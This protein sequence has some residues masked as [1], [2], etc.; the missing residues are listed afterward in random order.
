MLPQI[1]K[2]ENNKVIKVSTLLN[3]ITEL[4]EFVSKL[5]S[6][7]ILFILRDNFLFYFHI[8]ISLSF[9]KIRPVSFF[10][11]IIFGV[12]SFN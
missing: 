11:L 4:L 9:P 12:I 1:E 8:L 5:G 3:E 6:M 7:T 10:C 2:E